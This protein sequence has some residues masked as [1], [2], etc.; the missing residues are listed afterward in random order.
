MGVGGASERSVA[1]R[2]V[3][4]RRVWEGGRCWFGVSGEGDGSEG[5]GD[6]LAALLYVRRVK[7]GEDGLWVGIGIGMGGTM[8]SWLKFVSIG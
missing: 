7:R 3:M 4:L 6:V 5:G 2:W 1:A 8:L